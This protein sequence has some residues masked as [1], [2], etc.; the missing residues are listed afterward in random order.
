MNLALGPPSMASDD[1]STLI[2]A[3]VSLDGERKKDIWFR[4]SGPHEVSEDAANRAATA[5]LLIPALAMGANLVLQSKI[6]A[7][8]LEKL[9][10]TGEVL[11]KFFDLTTPI[12]IT[13]VEVQDHHAGPAR[14]TSRPSLIAFSGGVD[15]L[16]TLKQLGL[17]SG[18]SGSNRDTYR[19]LFMNTGQHRSSQVLF[20]QRLIRATTTARLLGIP[21]TLIDSNL[22]TFFPAHMGFKKTHTFRNLAVSLLL[23]DTHASFMYS[24]TYADG[25]SVEGVRDD[26]AAIEDLVMPLMSTDS[27]AFI[28]SGGT[29]R[30]VDKIQ[31][32]SSYPIA[33]KYLDVC[34]SFST[35]RNCSRCWKCHRTLANLEALGLLR[36]FSHAFFLSRWKRHRTRYLNSLRYQDAPLDSEL[37]AL[38]VERNI[39]I[40][41]QGWFHQ[42]LLRV[43][44][45]M[46]EWLRRVIRLLPS[47]PLYL[48]T[49]IKIRWLGSDPFR[50]ASSSM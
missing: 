36:D 45:A 48:A 46:P 18:V 4:A 42:G 49:L 2:T 24:S 15:S 9:R 1:T 47:L 5:S 37:R 20:H 33:R 27:Y 17:L 29:H 21:F 39:S 43:A 35:K 25:Q 50:L 11:R 22:E 34:V 13:A 38:L 8:Y 40:P 7:D 30:R 28:R 3:S 23:S 12:S 6:S 41:T 44:N 31:E 10:K 19:L 14:A 26:L 16:F 32:I